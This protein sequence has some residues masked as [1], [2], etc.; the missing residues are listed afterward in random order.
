MRSCKKPGAATAELKTMLKV[1]L[2]LT[3]GWSGHAWNSYKAAKFAIKLMIANS[4][5][6]T[7]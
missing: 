2:C 3:G 5:S 6:R 7:L 1:G 4:F